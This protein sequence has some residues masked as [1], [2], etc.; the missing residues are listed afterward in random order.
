MERAP[1]EGE[2]NAESCTR[3]PAQW[4]NRH[5]KLP[6]GCERVWLLFCMVQNVHLRGS[7]CVCVY[8]C[9]CAAATLQNQ[10]VPVTIMYASR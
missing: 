2:V 6:M 9:I 1:K 10:R 7:I 3:H 8:G 5:T 4:N